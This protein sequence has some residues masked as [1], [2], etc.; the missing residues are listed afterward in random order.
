M[1][2]SMYQASVP[3]FSNMLRGLSNVLRKAEENAQARKIEPSVFI[4]ARLAPDMLPLAKQVQIST[5]HAKGAPS[6]LAGRQAP[7]FEDTERTFDELQ[8]R[9]AKTRD[10][11]ATF[12]V[13]DLDGT[14]D[15]P[16]EIKTPTR[17]LSF[18]GSQYL[19]FFALPNFQ[20][21][22]TTAYSILRHNGV[23]LGKPDYLS[24]G[25]SFDAN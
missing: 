7:V 5:D 13:A 22:L 25:W 12:K 1:Q 3:I 21:H 6:R 17:P 15:N 20:F 2:L 9:I 24:G 23:P 8:A 19:L 4:E 11:L 16:I 18:T 10:Y 14:E